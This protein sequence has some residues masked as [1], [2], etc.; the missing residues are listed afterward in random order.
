[1]F[2]RVIHGERMRNEKKRCYVNEFTASAACL[3]LAA[4]LFWLEDWHPGGIMS[5]AHIWALIGMTADFIVL[6]AFSV[7]L[8]LRR[9]KALLFISLV[10]ITAAAA[11]LIVM[12]C[13]YT[14]FEAKYLLNLRSAVSADL[15]WILLAVILIL[16][17]RKKRIVRYIWFAPALGAVISL[18]CAVAQFGRLPWEA[19][20]REELSSPMIT[21]VVLVI[22]AQAIRLVFLVLT[23]L[24]LRS[25]VPGKAGLEDAP[26]EDAEEGIAE[27]DK[28]G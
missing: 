5:L 6:I 7:F 26:A 10:R 8:F 24:Y 17:V 11:E 15:A 14:E 12:F 23:G 20:V 1:M 2:R 3:L 9:T 4:A 18:C 22:S 27:E 21:D 25:T 13:I 16:T 28:A 19:W